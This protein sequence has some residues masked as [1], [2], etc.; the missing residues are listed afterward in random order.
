MRVSPKVG[1]YIDMN[2][3][4]PLIS[5]TYE[6]YESFNR[7]VFVFAPSDAKPNN[8]SSKAPK[9]PIDRQVLTKL[10]WGMEYK[11]TLKCPSQRKRTPRLGVLSFLFVFLLGIFG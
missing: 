1:L 3:S 8:S 6:V 7:P 5:G 2:Y 4:F 11:G 9:A 10:K